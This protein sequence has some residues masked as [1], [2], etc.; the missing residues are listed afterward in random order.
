VP[1]PNLRHAALTILFTLLGLLASAQTFTVIHT[2]TGGADGGYPY[3]GLVVDQNGNLYGTANTGGRGTCPP[4]NIGCGTVFKLVHSKTGWTFQR[5]Y[6]FRGGNDGQGPY[7]PV[8]IG[9]NG[10]LYGSTVD[11]GVNNCPSGCGLEN[12]PKIELL[13]P[14]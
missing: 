3:A 5:L 6:A 9:P 4:Q 2:F 14:A 1:N 10:N 8:T 12:P 13:G 7:G 11:G